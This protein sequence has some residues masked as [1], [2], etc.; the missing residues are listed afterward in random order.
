MRFLHTSD[1]HLGRTFNTRSRYDEQVAFI[2]WFAAQAAALEVDGIFIAG[3]VYD[4]SA[5]SEESVGLLDG[6]LRRLVE[7]C[8]VVLISGNHDS[9]HRLAYG[10]WAFESA[11]LHVRSSLDMVDTPVLFVDDTGNEVAVYGIHYLDPDQNYRPLET[12]RT[13]VQ[14]LSAAMEKVRTDLAARPKVRSVVLA[15]A[16]IAGGEESESER[17]ISVGG[18]AEAPI[19]VF[20]GID[21][22]ALGHLHRPQR[23]SSGGKHPLAHYSG[24]PLA[25]SFSEEHAKS[26]LVV[27]V[28]AQ[29]EVSV[30]AIAIPVGRPVAT[31]IGTVDELLG[32]ANAHHRESWVRISY[33]NDSRL[34][35]AFGRFEQCFPYLLACERVVP[36]RADNERD[37]RH[38]DPSVDAPIDV[39]RAFLEDVSE[40]GVRPGDLEALEDVINQ[41]RREAGVG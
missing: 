27:D 20:E 24:S 17:Q 29:G 38:V 2:D 41:V 35:D 12:G 30:E 4:R 11:G 3:D 33:V 16:F 25:Y 37:G 21:Y 19:S 1:W 7:I 18:A 9:S 40:D 13:H 14:V 26:I 32:A 10:G 39:L 36:G 8:P 22:L 31:L 6:A 28:P 5:P 23:V 34:D 15:H